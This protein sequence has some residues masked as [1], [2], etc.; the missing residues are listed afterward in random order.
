MTKDLIATFGKSD[1]GTHNWKYKDL[2]P[3]L[4]APQIKE[5]CELLTNLDICTQNGV[6]LFD[7]VVTAKVLTHKETLI[8][9]PEHE[10]RGVR[11]DGEPVVEEP[12]CEEVRC[13]EVAEEKI[14]LP[15]PKSFLLPETPH[16]RYLK[17]LTTIAPPEKAETAIKVEKESLSQSSNN[18]LNDQQPVAMPLMEAEPS[19]Q[20]TK[21][22]SKLLQWLHRIRKKN[23]EGPPD[24]LRE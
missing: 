23:K 19:S 14:A 13:F 9:D 6:K 21:E 15:T 5:A 17:Q 20:E 1:G 10:T 3:N 18:Q 2:D 8:F 12:T 4:T 7:S 24:S 22:R 11:Y 16:G